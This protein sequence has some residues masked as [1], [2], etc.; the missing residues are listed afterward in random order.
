MGF[1]SAVSMLCWQALW[2]P[3]PK[4]PALVELAFFFSSLKLSKMFIALLFPEGTEKLESSTERPNKQNISRLVFLWL[5][6][7]SLVFRCIGFYSE[8]TKMNNLP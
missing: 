3:L 1:P 2:T 7:L 6:F 5:S 4:I 8:V